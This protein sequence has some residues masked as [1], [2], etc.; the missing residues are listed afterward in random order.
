M[1]GYPSDSLAACLASDSHGVTKMVAYSGE[2][3]GYWL[4]V[5]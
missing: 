2:A 5:L 1:I 3:A 4:A